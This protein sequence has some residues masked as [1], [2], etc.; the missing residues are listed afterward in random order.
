[1]IRSSFITIVVTCSLP[2]RPFP[3]TAALTSLGV[4]R[5]TGSPRRA[6]DAIAIAPAWA[7]V[8]LAE[9]PFHGYR[10]GLARVQPALDLGLDGQQPRRDVIGG[11]RPDHPDPHQGQ[12]PPGRAIHHPD[13]APGQPGIDAEHPDRVPRI[14]QAHQGAPSGVRRGEHLFVTNLPAGGVPVPHR[15]RR[16]GERYPG[17]A[18]KDSSI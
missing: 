7:D 1:V 5:A 10:V 14:G 18:Q 2:A 11:R 8:L 12:R 6:A 13:A 16:V 9:D 17:P 4:C 3:V 15:D